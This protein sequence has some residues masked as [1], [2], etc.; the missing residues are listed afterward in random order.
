MPGLRLCSDVLQLTDAHHI[1]LKSTLQQLSLNLRSDTI[2]T[3][4][5]TRKDRRRGGIRRGSHGAGR[6]REDGEGGDV[7]NGLI[8]VVDSRLVSR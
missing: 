7:E 6:E 5:T 3:D 1:E 8:V 2:E 4:M